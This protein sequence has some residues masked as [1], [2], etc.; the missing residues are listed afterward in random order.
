MPDRRLGTSG[1]LMAAL[2]ALALLT[3][4][5]VA[6]WL[7][8][9]ASGEGTH[10]QLGMAPCGWEM[11]TGHPCPTCGMTTAFAHAANARFGAAAGTQPL[12]ALLAVLAS[13]AFWGSVHVGA[14]GSRIGA[15]SAAMIRPA[16]LWA[17][18]LLAV[19]AW[20]YKIL[21]T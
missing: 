13:A 7:R 6:A 20:I 14:T 12:G 5:G 16:T 15:V 17:L 11:V 3:V 10:T 18:A 19:A 1:R 21:V 2:L 9:D 4:L 8:P